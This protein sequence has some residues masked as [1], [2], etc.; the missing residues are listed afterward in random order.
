MATLTSQLFIGIKGHVVAI[1]VATGEELWRTKMKG[2]GLATV[3]VVGG[4]LYGAANGEVFRLDPSTG[5]IVW[6]N[7]L[8]GLGLGI[9][10]FPGSDAPSAEQTRHDSDAAA[11]AAV[12]AAS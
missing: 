1:D 11:G 7:K 3:A 12:V 8:P 5:Q 9:V 10:T 2:S 4:H 6:Q